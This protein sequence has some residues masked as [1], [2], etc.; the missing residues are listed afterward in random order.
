MSRKSDKR[1]NRRKRR[2]V[3]IRKFYE[4]VGFIMSYEAFKAMVNALIIRKKLNIKA[5]FYNDTEKG[6]YYAH[7]N[8]VKIIGTPT[9]KKITVKWGSGHTAMVAV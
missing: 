9:S 7:C 1:R 2:S 8:G 4:K 5:R 6:M 3:G